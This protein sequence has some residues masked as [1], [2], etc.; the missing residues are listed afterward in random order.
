MSITINGDTGISGVDGSASTPAIQGNDTNTGLFFPSADSVALSTN[1]TAALTV[2]SSQVVSLVNA[3]PVAS[4][5]TGLTSPGTSGNI[6]T[7]NGTAWVSQ[8]G[9]VADGSITDPKIATL[10]AG[11]NYIGVSVQSYSAGGGV[12][13]TTYTKKNEYTAFRAGTYRFTGT[14]T[15]NNTGP[16][17]SGTVFCQI[18][19][20]GAATGS[21]I[22]ASLATNSTSTLQ[23]FADV[24]VARGDLVQFFVR[25]SATNFGSSLTTLNIGNSV[26]WGFSAISDNTPF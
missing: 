21:I 15:N 24:T 5:G 20:N 2:N 17:A 14:L 8:A 6:L 9:G 3:L 4:G 1:G 18:Y 12:T 10:S 25:G 16:A 7:S 22:S 11:T 23:T 19:I 13:S 26:L